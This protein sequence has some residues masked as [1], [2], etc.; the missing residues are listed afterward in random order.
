ML[1]LVVVVIG[2]R[3]PFHAAVT[4]P[5]M[6]SIS[7]I[8]VCSGQIVGL[9][10]TMALAMPIGR[11]TMRQERA[12]TAACRWKLTWS[13]SPTSAA[14]PGPPSAVARISLVNNYY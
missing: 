2:P 12:H 7:R 4:A 13:L 9:A 5:P 8:M 11:G 3:E 10:A 1:S 6:S 14:P